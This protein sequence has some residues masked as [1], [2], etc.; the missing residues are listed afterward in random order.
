M[1]NL[2]ITKKLVCLFLVFGLIPMA[3]VA[4]IS[5]HSINEMAAKKLMRMENISKTVADKIDRNLFERYGDVQAFGLNSVI[6]NK[7]YWYKTDEAENKIVEKMNQYVDTYDIYYLTTLVDLE[8]KVIAVN[9]KDE[10]G[11]PIDSAGL[12][13]KD[14]SNTAWFKALSKGEFTTKQRFTAAGNDVSNGTFIE[15]LYV[16]NDVKQIYT[17]D[18]GLSLGFSAPV[19]KDGEIIAYWN[20]RTRFALVEDIFKASYQQLKNEGFN[21]VELTLLDKEGRV[22]VDHDPTTSGTEEIVHNFDNV[23]MK[24]NLAEKGVASAQAGIKGES[25]YMWS[26]HAR[27]GIT[28]GAGYSPLVGALG[29]PGTE[30]VVLA[31]MDKSEVEGAVFA[32]ARLMIGI[33]VLAAIIAI[34]AFGLWF[35]RRMAKPIQGMSEVAENIARGDLSQDVDWTSTDET[36]RLADSFRTVMTTI[37]NLN[38]EMSEIVTAVRNGELSK[39]GDQDRFEGC[40]NEIIS[41]ANETLDAYNAP[42]SDAIQ[43][44]EQLASNDLTERMSTSY[45]GEFAKISAAVNQAMDNL[46]KTITQVSGTEKAVSH[47]A[48]KVHENSQSIAEG[49][50]EQASALEEIASSLEEMT[51]MTR[52]S[53]D[54]ANQAKLL[55]NDTRETAENGNSAMESMGN[56]IDKIKASSDEQ[57]KIVKTIDEI[58]FQTNLLALNAAV[59]AARAGEAGKGFA[60]VAE[61]VRS[62]AQRSAEA[63]RTTSTMIEESVANSESGVK[64]AEDVGKVLIEIKS[65]AQKTSDLVAE[66]AAASNE[67]AQGIEQVNSAVTQLDHVT[68]QSATVSQDS[69]SSAEELTKQVVDLS[70]L[71][72]AFTLNESDHNTTP[73]E[74]D[75]HAAVKDLSSSMESINSAPAQPVP[76]TVSPSA[77]EMIPFDDEEGFDDF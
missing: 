36:G 46:G 65:S 66:I 31:R 15:D 35:G 2:T 76:A 58:A 69:A 11:E 25:G 52:Q 22:I 43:T 40:Y 61:E 51:S 74:E 8:G 26:E 14:Y 68:Q 6:E 53:A 9:S 55:A 77:E 33:S 67:Q 47:S 29:Y 63:A 13:Q 30:W 72:S 73:V 21:S 27:K 48:V 41:G 49:A 37:R 39:R 56:A 38:D 3:L 16:D 75:I 18:D 12:Y 60:V 62:L 32:Q 17:G 64:I 4:G 20:N 70:R 7:D 57:A 45:Q 34:T 28:Q 10:N 19:Y 54:N 23:L 59:E 50:T 44:M 1:K 5:F 24:L 71:V 42:I